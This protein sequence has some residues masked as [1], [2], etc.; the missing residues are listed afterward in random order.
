MIRIPLSPLSLSIAC[1]MMRLRGNKIISTLL[2]SNALHKSFSINDLNI[3]GKTDCTLFHVTFDRLV[4]VDNL[5]QYWTWI[6]KIM[7]FWDVISCR[8][9]K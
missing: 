5:L 9:E 2:S 8:F 1:L 4:T 7:V 3:L 6:S